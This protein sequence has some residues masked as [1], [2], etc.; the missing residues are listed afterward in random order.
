MLKQLFA[1]Y[2]KAMVWFRNYTI[3][4][5][6]KYKK[7]RITV[8]CYWVSIAIFWVNDFLKEQHSGNEEHVVYS[9][10]LCLPSTKLSVHSL[11][12]RQVFYPVYVCYTLADSIN[13][14][15]MKLIKSKQTGNYTKVVLY[16]SCNL[17]DAFNV[18]PLFLTLTGLCINPHF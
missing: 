15:S 3:N 11:L 14:H 4:Q 7:R 17:K 12:K 6:V 18:N 2:C 1:H 9:T 10:R 8:R 5:Q 16:C 13:K